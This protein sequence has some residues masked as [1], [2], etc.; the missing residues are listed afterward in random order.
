VTTTKRRRLTTDDDAA[1]LFVVGEQKVE[2]E[3]Q[4]GDE[5]DDVDRGA[6][7]SQFARTH[8]EPDHDLEREPGVADALDVEERVVGVGAFLVQ[9]PGG[10]RASVG[11]ND[12]RRRRQ[13]RQGGR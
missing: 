6:D 4:R 7:E 9:H 10:R 5:V 2:V 13:R 12:V 1:N 3:R 8:D 11:P